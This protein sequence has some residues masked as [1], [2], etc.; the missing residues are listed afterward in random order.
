MLIIII[1]IILLKSYEKNISLKKH[2]KY[3][4]KMPFK[5]NL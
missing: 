1:I 5:G 4:K 2:I 3:I